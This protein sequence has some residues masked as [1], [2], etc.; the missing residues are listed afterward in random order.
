MMNLLL[1]LVT[2]TGTAR[3][4]LFVGVAVVLTNNWSLI[5]S[6]ADMNEKTLTNVPEWTIKV[7]C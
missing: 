1:E 4:S 6:E 7:S 2:M 3:T 5:W